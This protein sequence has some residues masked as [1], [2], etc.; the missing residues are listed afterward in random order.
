LTAA[1]L[2]V[3]YGE[4]WRRTRYALHLDG[5]LRHP[6][7]AHLSVRRLIAHHDDER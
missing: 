7:E 1:G 5:T 3:A 4:L 6:A 2:V